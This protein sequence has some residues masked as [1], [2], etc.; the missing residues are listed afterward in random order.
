MDFNHVVEFYEKLSMTSKRLEIIDILANLFKECAKPENLPDFRKVIY[1]TQGRLVSE[2]E[3]WPKFGIAEKL[4]IQALIKF[5]GINSKKIKL[6]IIKYGDVGIAV[7]QILEQRGKKKVAYSMDAFTS[8]SKSVSS[9]KSPS[10]SSS[11]SSSKSS[12]ISKPSGLS[13]FIKSGNKISEKTLEISFLYSE[14]EKLSNVKGTGSQDQKINI[15]TGLFHR[16]TPVSAKYIMNIILSTLRLGLADMTILDSLAKAFTG[17]KDNRPRIQRAYNLYP[18]LGE[19]ARVLLEKG[20]DG[21]DRVTIQVGIPIKMMLASRIQY[22]QIP[23]KLGGGDFIGEY[24][25]DGERV[26]VHKHGSKVKLFSRQLK[27]STAQYPDV[28]QAVLK[29]VKAEDAIFEGEI[30]AMGPFFEKMLPFQVVST[31]RRKYNIEKMQKEVPVCLFCF[32]VLYLD[33]NYIKEINQQSQEQSQ[34]QDQNLNLVPTE[35]PKLIPAVNGMVMD[36][37]LLQR[38]AYLE[39]L[40]SQNDVIRYS[41]FRV[42]HSTEEM[43][44]FFKEAR[45]KGAEGIMNKNMGEGSVYQ[46]GKRG[47]LWIKLKGLEGA[48]MLDTID[49][50]LIGASWGKGRRKGVMSPFFGAVYNNETGRFEFLT[51][52]GSGFS[53]DDLIAFTEELKE[54]EITKK[55]IDVICSDIPD[56]WLKP[57]IIIEIMGDELTISSKAD[58][59]ASPGE[60][61]GY[62]LRFPV[63]QRRRLDKDIHQITTTKEIFNMYKA[64]D[65]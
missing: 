35:K 1:L 19:I 29:S 14:L 42:L 65:Q 28:V 46:A 30:V 58:A 60:S 20:M 16:S 44:E 54:F 36:L 47:F 21:I 41:N 33:E 55:P 15:I 53:D 59:G 40:F 7:Q 10:S 27:E 23:Q 43:V 8:S 57:K 52:V 56:V 26:Q 32:D 64:Q 17:T 62:G 6:L 49:V 2:I 37:P 51:R 25:Y 31:R 4:I 22:P 5:T 13:S 9:P 45:A 48:K 61:N 39:S 34:K 12:K 24:K 11:S 63:Y 38:R 50:V 18:D 3:E